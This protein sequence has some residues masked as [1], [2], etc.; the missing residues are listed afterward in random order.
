MVHYASKRKKNWDEVELA[1]N[2]RRE[3]I[4][5][6][7]VARFACCLSQFF[8][9]AKTTIFFEGP[10]VNHSITDATFLCS[11]GN[12]AIKRRINFFSLF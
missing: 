7:A 11:R 3:V 12:L 9:T 10:A 8:H 2:E 5:E 6:R 4:D 1:T